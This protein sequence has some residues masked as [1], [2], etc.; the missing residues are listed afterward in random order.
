[1]KQQKNNVFTES[2]SYV[3]TLVSLLVISIICVLLAFC[4][5]T[6][7]KSIV[8]TKQKAKE[9][10][11]ILQFD[12]FLRNTINSISVPAWEKDYTFTYS[13]NNIDLPWVNGKKEPQNTSIPEDF[14]IEKAETIKYK[15]SKPAGLKVIYTYNKKEYECSCLFSS[16]PYG[17]E[18]L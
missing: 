8:K 3:E 16:I 14:I 18:N 10:T 2:F 6:S 11:Q 7:V 4:Y 15:N 1:M 17:V 13:K 5:S 9:A 12:T